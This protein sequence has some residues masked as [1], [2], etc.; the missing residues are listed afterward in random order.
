V[1]LGAAQTHGADTVG[2]PWISVATL[3]ELPEGR[4]LE[5]EHGGQL[6]AVCNFDGEIRATSGICPH[7]GGPLGQ[8][9]LDGPLITCPWH[10]WQF[11][12]ATGACA[13]IPDLC[14]PV[15]PVRIEKTEIFVELPHA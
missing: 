8:G 7:H 5:V 11:D 6:F 10:M 13:S 4:L 2:M 9:A 14:I 1:S 3:D 12:S 15:Y